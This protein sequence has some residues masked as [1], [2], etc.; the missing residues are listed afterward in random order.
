M[1]KLFVVLLIVISFSSHASSVFTSDQCFQSS[2]KVDISNDL[3][4]GLTKRSLIIDKK[5]C[6]INVSYKN[7][8]EKTWLVDICR[9][10]IHIKFNILQI[11]DDI[12][13]RISTCEKSNQS[14]YCQ[15]YFELMS[16]I[17]GFALIY[18]QGAK[19]DIKSAHGKVYCSNLLLKKY[20]EQG[21]LFSSFEKAPFLFDSTK[22]SEK[23]REKEDESRSE[24]ELE[25]KKAQP[26]T[27]AEPKK[28]RIF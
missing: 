9:E 12:Y 20:L 21:F 26:S 5:K 13:K 6:Q 15:S 7:F 22:R 23:K 18:A 3:L 25:D 17:Q 14:D 11:V 10:P 27:I 8:I 4:F 2:F 19:E 24:I 16:Y 28:E 1:N